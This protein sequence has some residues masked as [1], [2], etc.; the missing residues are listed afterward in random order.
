MSTPGD[1]TAAE[2]ITPHAHVFLGMPPNLVPAI[3]Q[4]F[5]TASTTIRH[6]KIWVEESS[7]TAGEFEIVEA[8]PPNQVFTE[9][10]D[11]LDLWLI[12]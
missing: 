10:T 4:T 8:Y 5:P 3:Q 12:D 6:L 9:V 7:D 2:R 11:A 1:Q